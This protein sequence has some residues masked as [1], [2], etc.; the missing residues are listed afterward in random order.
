MK[1]E[2]ITGELM[3]VGPMINLLVKLIY[4]LILWDMCLAISFLIINA[5]F[6]GYDG[7]A[8]DAQHAIT[9]GVWDF[10]Q[11]VFI[12]NMLCVVITVCFILNVGQ[13]TRLM[14]GK[15]IASKTTA[16]AGG[17]THQNTSSKSSI[18]TNV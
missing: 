3:K 7:V 8:L 16:T 14:E 1:R 11:C 15:G 9:L 10:L 6:L 12:I 5:M 13:L 4:L 17:T 18:D 2:K